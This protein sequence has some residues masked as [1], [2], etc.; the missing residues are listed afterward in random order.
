MHTRENFTLLLPVAKKT[1]RGKELTSTIRGWPL[2]PTLR[3]DLV[4]SQTTS[5]DLE[6][7]GTG[8]TTLSSCST[9]VHSYLS[10]LP[11]L[12]TAAEQKRD[13]KE[14]ALSQNKVERI[15]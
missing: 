10:V 14:A 2:R 12:P 11:P 9:W 15:A 4:M 6:P 1:G 5:R 13:E 8:T 7:S 3:R